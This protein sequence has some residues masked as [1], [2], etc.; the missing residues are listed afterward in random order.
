MKVKIIGGPNK[1]EEGTLFKEVDGHPVPVKF[2]D[3][4]DSNP[5]QIFGFVAGDNGVSFEVKL[6]DV[7]FAD[8]VPSE[9]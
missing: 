8:Q 3:L 1:G 9:S 6:G 4:K 5:E 2:E 7:D